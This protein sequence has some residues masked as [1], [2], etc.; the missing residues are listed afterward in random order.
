MGD[1]RVG[2]PESEKTYDQ[3]SISVDDFIVAT[4]QGELNWALR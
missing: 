1:P 4:R 2:S 3:Q